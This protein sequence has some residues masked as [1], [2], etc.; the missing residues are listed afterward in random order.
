MASAPSPS[1]IAPASADG[2]LNVTET[3]QLEDAATTSDWQPAHTCTNH[4]LDTFGE[5]AA[6]Q[7]EET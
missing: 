1:A 3:A 6:R 2:K 5:A 7:G 4:L